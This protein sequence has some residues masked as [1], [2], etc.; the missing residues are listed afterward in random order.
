MKTQEMKDFYSGKYEVELTD[1]LID[2]LVK[3]NK[4]SDAD[5]LKQMRKQGAKWNTKRN[6]VVYPVEFI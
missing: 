6:S 4:W 2:K 3:E 5:S 1:E